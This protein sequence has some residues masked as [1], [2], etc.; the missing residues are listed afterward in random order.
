LTIF[1]KN[2]KMKTH[3]QRFWD[4]VQI[5]NNNE[6]WEWKA[7]LNEKRYGIL[8]Y[9][10]KNTRA[11]RMSWMIHHGDV[12]MGMCV[13][14]KCDN[15]SCVNP[16]HLFLGTNKD[17]SV[18][19]MRKGRNNPPKGEDSYRAILTEKKVIKIRKLWSSGIWKQREIAN[20][21]GIDR[22]HVSEIVRRDIWKHI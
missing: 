17:N 14:H 5:G 19:M 10:R 18:D 12:P 9:N 2:Q 21:F 15:P 3:K 1:F 16:A 8:W 7:Q 20:M 4:K 13:L 11:H 6:C 22:S